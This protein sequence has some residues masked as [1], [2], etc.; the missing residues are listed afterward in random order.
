MAE[1]LEIPKPKQKRLEDYLLERSQAAAGPK[2]GQRAPD[3]T[4]PLTFAQEQVWLHAQLAPDTP[5]YNEPF[6]IHRHGP[7]DVPALE[8]AFT[9]VVRRHEAWR[10]SFNVVDGQPVQ[11]VHPPFEIKL[12]VKDFSALPE[13]DAKAAALQ[14]ATED[15]RR[16]FA[17]SAAPPIREQLARIGKEEYRL[18][19]NC[20]HLIFDGVTAYQVFLPELV[21]LYEAFSKGQPSPLPALP[22]QYADY[23]IWQRESSRSA[24]QEQKIAYWKNKLAG[25]LPVLQLPV[26]WPQASVESFRGAM[27]T[28]AIPSD[29][30]DGLREFSRKHGATLFMTMLAALNALLSR[31]SGQDD[32]LIGSVT[33]GRNYPGSEKLLGFFLNT[34]VLR[35]DLAGDPT[36]RELL[37]RVRKTTI[38]ALSHDD[39]PLNQVVKE[40][41]PDRE[42]TRNPL[43][44]VLLSMEP[45]F[46]NVHGGW[47]LTPIEVETGT[48]KF[49]L[50]VVLDERPN[51]ISGRM[52]YSTD[53]FDESTISRAVECWQTLLKSVVD[54]PERRLSECSILAK[55]DRHKL[56][57]DWSAPEKPFPFVPV[58]QQF[59]N[60]VQKTPAAI[61]LKCGVEAFSY[62]ELNQRAE[63]LANYLRQLGVGPEVPVGICIERSPEMI[64]GI[65]GVLKAGGAYVPMDPTYPEERLAFMLHDSQAPVLLTQ[66]KLR[67]SSAGNN[68]RVVKLDA[69]WKEIAA[70]P[71][72]KPEE[73]E[74]GDLAYIIYTSGSTG[75]PKGVEVTHGN[76][77]HSNSARLDFY[78]DTDGTYLLLSSIGFDSS[79]ATIFHALCSGGTLVLLPA[80]LNIEARQIAELILREKV[81]SALCVP[82]LYHDVL[83]TVSPDMLKSLRRVILA[84]EASTAPLIQRH[85]QVLPEVEL[86]NEYG[87]TEGSVW[88]T[89][90]NFGRELPKESAVPIGRPISNTRAYVLD[91]NLQLLPPG[92]AGELFIA[93]D[94]LA[95]GYRNKPELTREKFLAD[96]F[97]ENPGERMYRTGD[98][99]R[100]NTNGDLQFLGR[101]DEQI[102]F[103]G[104]RIELGEIETVLSA[105]PD[106]REAVVTV[107]EDS[108]KPR[109]IAHIVVNEKYATSAAELRA[110]VK[111]RLPNYMVPSGFVFAQKLPRTPNGKI[112][113]VALA[114]QTAVTNESNTSRGAIAQDSFEA[115]L[116][117]IWKNVLAVQSAEI[118]QDF[119]ELGGDSLLAAKLLYEIEQE[120]HQSLPLAFVF[121]AP[122][123]EM[124]ADAL[125]SPDQSLRA[126]AIVEIQPNGSRPPLFCIRAGPRF[127]L[128]AQ[129]LGLDRPFLGVDIPYADAVKLPTPYRIEDMAKFMI[130][131]MREVQPN[132]PYYI[133][134]LCV[135]AVIAYEVARQLRAEGEQIALLAMFDGH[136]GAYYKNPLRDG[137]YTGRIKYHVA[138]LLKLDLK[139]SSAYV[140]HRL[141]EARRKVERT[142]W[143]L[144]AEGG[145][146][147][148]GKLRNTDSIIHPAYHRFEPSPYTGNIVLFQSSDWPDGDY[149]NFEIGWKDLIKGGI[150]F[151][152]IPGNHPSMFREPNVN[153]LASGLQKH[154]KAPPEAG[155]DGTNTAQSTK[156][157]AK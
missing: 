96:P 80:E 8:R 42:L 2:I 157:Q 99:V 125:R 70:A 100:Y 11:V 104:L 15:A 87:P 20:H 90:Y 41:H 63:Q 82:S 140:F 130:K 147:R 64:V 149:F 60:A 22:F 46:T 102:K 16:P 59:E 19:V 29:V 85:F 155:V 122:T 66:A 47:D 117:T 108:Q 116:S 135:N 12:P 28:F 123:V 62:A 152:R 81:S 49:D 54:N 26:D 40:L 57:V 6:T 44:R 127:R 45:S 23:A 73:I 86:F 88:S 37:E 69:D 105:H 39:V 97:K 36:F 32:I 71:Q 114:K 52:I 78:G 24:S 139:E 67:V 58:H 119:F 156:T 5:A 153:V 38:D 56:L 89:V 95:R 48:A 14:L 121:Q 17:L 43:F 112:D 118:T 93:G 111:S 10:T 84:G 129:K 9:E 148:G 106:I 75:E 98:V 137:R 142:M 65:L 61:A 94:G 138:N 144:T 27:Q 131:A 128:L 145:A 68:T 55:A 154:L 109:L 151:H 4:A 7:L 34:I 3:A 50:C 133:A 150:E 92:V 21:A 30:T 136:N 146:D 35:N 103:R 115:K 53:L 143:L 25:P 141:E 120:F 18:F 1:T 51:G 113:R 101:V 124:M 74:P 134:G 91:R 110:F 77:S 31:Y 72:R 132:G 107:Q 79:V 126:R 13:A 83:N 33:A 76:L